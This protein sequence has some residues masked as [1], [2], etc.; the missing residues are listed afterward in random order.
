MRTVRM[1]TQYAGPSGVTPPGGTRNVGDA[2]AAS[3]V[4]GGYAAYVDAHEAVDVEESEHVD[5]SEDDSGNGY[6]Y[7]EEAVGPES[8]SRETADEEHER[9]P[10]GT[11]QRRRS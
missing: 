1:Y 9:R 8:E 3:L 10:S 7:V 6:T 2:E 11:R 5:A 4:D